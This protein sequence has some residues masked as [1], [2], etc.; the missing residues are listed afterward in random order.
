MKFSCDVDNIHI[1]I[2]SFKRGSSPRN[3][4]KLCL[5]DIHIKATKNESILIFVSSGHHMSKK[6]KKLEKDLPD[7]IE[8]NE[9]LE[10]VI[11]HMDLDD[12]ED[13]PEWKI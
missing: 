11:H 7:L 10:H 9:L 2:E 3:P 13:G 8:T 12:S 4:K 6:E 5:I 1:E